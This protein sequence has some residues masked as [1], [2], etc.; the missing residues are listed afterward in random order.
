MKIM[1]IF[2]FVTLPL[3]A[4]LTFSAYLAGLR[5]DFDQVNAECDDNYRGGPSMWSIYIT[6]MCCVAIAFY[7]WSVVATSQTPRVV[8]Q[9]AL[10]RALSYVANFLVT[11]GPRSMHGL[12]MPVVGDD[13]GFGW[14]LLF[15]HISWALLCL[16]G[17]FNVLTYAFQNSQHS[18]RPGLSFHVDFQTDICVQPEETHL[19]PDMSQIS[20]GTQRPELREGEGLLERHFGLRP[21]VDVAGVSVLST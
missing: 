3:A 15:S 10:L 1:R 12:L 2:L 17:L 14:M 20:A 4:L 6:V 13:D 7:I 19:S 18:R 8:R 11:F 21:H 5:P 9:K 16:N